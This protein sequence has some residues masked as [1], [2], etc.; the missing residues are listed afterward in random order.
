M[1]A[2]A[3]RVAYIPVYAKPMGENGGLSHNRACVPRV[4]HFWAVLV[5]GFDRGGVWHTNCN[6][7]NQFIDNLAHPSIASTL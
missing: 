1:L 3:K 6:A 4:L 7:Y 5:S 2:I